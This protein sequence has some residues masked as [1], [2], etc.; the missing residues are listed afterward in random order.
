MTP[1]VRIVAVAAALLTASCSFHSTAT[2]WN[3][4]VDEDGKPVFVK[5]TTNIG[6]N[7]LVIIP[8]LGNSTIEAMLDETTAEIAE[9]GGNR[10]RVIQ[11]GSENYWYGWSPFTWVITPIVTDVALEYEPSI[12][13][14]KQRRKPSAASSTNASANCS[15]ATTATVASRRTAPVRDRD[16]QPGAQRG[17]RHDQPTWLAIPSHR[18]LTTA[19]EPH[20]A[21]GRGCRPV[22]TSNPAVGDPLR[23]AARGLVHAP[24]AKAA[25]LAVRAVRS[26]PLPPRSSAAST[27]PWTR[28][29]F[30]AR[31]WGEVF[32]PARVEEHVRRLH[33]PVHD[34]RWCAVMAL[35]ET[36]H[37]RR[38]ARRRASC[39][40]AARRR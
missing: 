6:F 27:Q 16:D 2:K 15:K 30:H 1:T 29:E 14:I 28:V 38:R 5:T 34:A 21:F 12:E 32:G 23:R 40:P 10:V 13:E 7:L 9:E 36:A 35:A 25:L 31:L 37:A 26:P 24:E 20:W 18:V 3:G 17:A 39:E 4:R 33:V 22:A 19:V 11:T 8:F